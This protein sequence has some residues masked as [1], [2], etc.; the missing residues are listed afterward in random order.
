[1]DILKF[2]NLKYIREHLRNIGY[3]YKRRDATIEKNI[4]CGMSVLKK[5]RIV[6]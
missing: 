5:C 2:I 3:I 1:M 6:R 4:K